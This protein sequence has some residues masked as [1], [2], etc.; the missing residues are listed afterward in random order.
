M[1]KYSIVNHKALLNDV[2]IRWLAIV[3]KLL[4]YAG[5]SKGGAE[6]LSVMKTKKNSSLRFSHVFGPKLDE[7]H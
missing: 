6:K 4:A 2:M 5:F 7:D 1:R 3:V